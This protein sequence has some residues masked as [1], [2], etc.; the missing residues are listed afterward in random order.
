[1]KAFLTVI[2]TLAIA[3]PMRAVAANVAR[4]KILHTFQAEQDGGNPQGGLTS[5]SAG[6]LYGATSTGGVGSA[7]TIFRLSSQPG[8]GLEFYSALLLCIRQ[9]PW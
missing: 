1:M 7:G 2:C 8:G 5:D 6:N 3:L 4:E 9:R